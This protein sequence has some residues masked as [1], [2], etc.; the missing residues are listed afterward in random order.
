MKSLS[1]QLAHLHTASSNLE[2]PK[3]CMLFQELIV[4]DLVCCPDSGMLFQI[5]I[6]LL[7][8]LSQVSKDVLKSLSSWMI[9]THS[10]F[11][12]VTHFCSLDTKDM[13]DVFQIRK[14]ATA[15]VLTMMMAVPFSAF[16]FIIQYF[17]KLKNRTIREREIMRF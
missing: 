5:S 16:H 4:T 14:A 9:K 6:L 15:L 7:S 1:L 3:L 11:C 17:N 2:D 12:I 10:L 8:S 13:N